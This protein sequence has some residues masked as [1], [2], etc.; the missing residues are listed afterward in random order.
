MP[1][2]WEDGLANSTGAEGGFEPLIF[3]DTG[4]SQIVKILGIARHNHTWKSALLGDY[5]VRYEYDLCHLNFPIW[6]Y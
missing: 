2:L 5:Q 3:E 4:G 6:H 1:I